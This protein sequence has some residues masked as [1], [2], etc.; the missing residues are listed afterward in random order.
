V[1]ARIYPDSTAHLR[2]AILDAFDGS[3]SQLQEPFRHMSSN[4]LTPPTFSAD[5][6]VTTVDPGGYL[7]AYRMLPADMRSHDVLI[8]DPTGDFYWNSEYGTTDTDRPVRFH[9]GFILHLV[10]QGP[11]STEVQV[12]ELVPSVWPGEHWAFSAHGV[13]VGRYHDIRFVE[14]TVTDRVQVLELLDRVLRR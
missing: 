14:P 7:D 6:L 3:R 5:W 4:A 8:Q 1:V 2:A 10:T 9:C 13:G 12:Y 11:S